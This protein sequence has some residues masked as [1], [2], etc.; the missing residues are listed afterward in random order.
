MQTWAKHGLIQRGPYWLKEGGARVRGL[1]IPLLENLKPV[2]AVE[3]LAKQP[4]VIL[5]SSKRG[6]ADISAQWRTCVFLSDRD[7]ILLVRGGDIK[8]MLL[9]AA[10]ES[11]IGTKISETKAN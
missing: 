7:D 6:V 1:I 8:F 5:K 11:E 2:S 10:E 3:E 9:Q 4:V